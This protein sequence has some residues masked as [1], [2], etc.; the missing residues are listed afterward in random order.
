[1]RRNEEPK[2][3]SKASIGKNDDYNSLLEEVTR[4]RDSMVLFLVRKS[5]NNSYLWA[6]GWAE[7]KFEVTTGKL[8]LPNDGSIDLSLFLK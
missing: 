1:M 2:V 3:I 7:S 5:G 4:T 8:P 6:A